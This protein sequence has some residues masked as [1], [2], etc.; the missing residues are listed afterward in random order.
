MQLAVSVRV[1]VASAASIQDWQYSAAQ[2]HSRA[3]LGPGWQLVVCFLPEAAHSSSTQTTLELSSSLEHSSSSGSMECSLMLPLPPACCRLQEGGWLSVFAVKQPPIPA[4]AQQQQRLPVVTLQQQRYV[5]VLQLSQLAAANPAS[6]LLLSPQLPTSCWPVQQLQ[7][8]AA[9]PSQP[10]LTCVV[11]LLASASEAAA[12]QPLLKR[13]RS[14]AAGTAGAQQQLD[15]H[16]APGQQQL[17]EWLSSVFC[18]GAAAN[19]SCGRPAQAVTQALHR[20]ADSGTAIVSWAAAQQELP[21]ARLLQA[22]AAATAQLALS[23]GVQLDVRLEGS[24]V[25][26]IAHA[27]RALMLRL[28]DELCGGSG[29]SSNRQWCLTASSRQLQAA[30]VRLRQLAAHMLVMRDAGDRAREAAVGYWLQDG[31]SVA[32][33]GLLKDM[34]AWRRGLE[35]GYGRLLLAAGEAACVRL[36]QT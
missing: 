28:I 17:S 33:A 27:H 36:Q 13:Q 19:I 20:L 32:F 4:A 15:A 12:K 11:R 16:A 5:G 29:G 34:Q 22:A 14:D 35:A 7:P 6:R 9:S 1:Q 30:F 10:P 2:Q 18:A 3:T 25:A 8:G 26:A 31:S 24:S 21:S 23:E